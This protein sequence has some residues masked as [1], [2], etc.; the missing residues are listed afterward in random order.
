MKK[1]V[2]MLAFVSFLSLGLVAS[3]SYAAGTMGKSGFMMFNSSDLIGAP[4]KDSHGQPMGIVDEVRVDS[5]GHAF[6]A[7]IHLD[8]DLYGEGG[9]NSSM[10]FQELRISQI[11]AGQVTVVPKTDTKYLDFVPYLNP[12]KT[13][14][15][16]FGANTEYYGIQ[17]YWIQSGTAGK[18]GFM[19]LNTFNP[20]GATVENPIGEVVGS[21]H[22]F[23]IDSNGHIDLVIL[24]YN[25]PSEYAPVPPQTIAVP[26]SEITV[27]P[28]GKVAVLKFSG[29]KL[30]LAP[31]FAKSDI[32]NHKWTEND[33]RYFGQSPY[34]TERGNTG[35]KDPY[36]WGGE[37]QNF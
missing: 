26:F 32:N 14:S 17:P 24:T 23:V 36:R 25:F 6:A 22:D 4:A 15:R 19:E 3:N 28:N 8:Y 18:S 31:K 12:P 9:V 30:E 27:K 13:D 33:Y 16:Q 21:I 5:G 7:V 37:A 2:L 11:K 35:A 29:W 34:W 20:V 10:P 1:T